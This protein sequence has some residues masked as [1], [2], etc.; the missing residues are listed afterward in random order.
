MSF[1]SIQID[2]ISKDYINLNGQIANT[3]SLQCR[4]Y[5]LLETKRSQWLYAPDQSYGSELKTL[6]GKRG[7]VNKTQLTQ[8]IL[9]A[10]E[11]LTINGDL[12]ITNISIPTITVAS[13]VIDIYGID[14]EGQPI[15]FALPP[16]I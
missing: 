4:I 12:V 15:H 8:M 6:L 14:A 2:T 13:S 16:L 3:N 5:Q 11:P 9:S 10:L 7:R 1:P